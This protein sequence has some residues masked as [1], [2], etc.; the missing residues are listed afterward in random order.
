MQRIPLLILAFIIGMTAAGISASPQEPVRQLSATELD[1]LNNHFEQCMNH[2]PCTAQ[3]DLLILERMTEALRGELRH[4]EQAC[5]ATDYKKC[6]N[7]A[8]DDVIQWYKLH[9][10]IGEM[11]VILQR[12]YSVA[13]KT[14]KQLNQIEPAAGADP[15]PNPYTDPDLEQDKRD[16]RDW[17]RG[18]GWVP[19]E[20]DNPYQ[21][22]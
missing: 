20:E 12:K 2:K 11:A 17:W 18:A 22:W 3:Q 8:A 5:R 13:N 15:Y 14:G 6:F 1:M 16:Q 4:I 21:K 19:P 9:D 7:P 10:H